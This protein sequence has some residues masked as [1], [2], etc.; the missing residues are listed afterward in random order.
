MT[1]GEITSHK[2]EP[3]W[4]PETLYRRGV[5]LSAIQKAYPDFRSGKRVTASPDPKGDLQA[6]V[7]AIAGA[8]GGNVPLEA[9]GC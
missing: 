6:A 5:S 4:D 3:G 1:P 8:A 9:I 2:D 7:D